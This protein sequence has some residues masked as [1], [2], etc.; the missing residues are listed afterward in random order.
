MVNELVVLRLGRYFRHPH[1]NHDVLSVGDRAVSCANIR[2]ALEYLDVPVEESETTED[3]LYTAALTEG[4]KR[5]QAQFPQAIPDGQVGPNTR[6]R[7]VDR[8]LVKYGT[9]IFG[10]LR[11]HGAGTKP[12]VF[13]SYASEDQQKAEKLDQWLRDKDVYV[14]RDANSFVVGHTIE[15]NIRFAVT[16]ADKVVALYSKQSKKKDWPRLELALGEDLERE[17]KERLLIYVQLDGSALPAHDPNRLAITAVSPRTLR[18]VGE[19]LLFALYDDY[20]KPLQRIRVN[21]DE[22]L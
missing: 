12:V 5:F 13:L 21:E 22:P 10:R 6:R 15:E 11:R 1:V 18:Q 19:E 3:Q 20:E 17:L 2:R 16:R 8:L 7:L 4:V 14:I 9:S